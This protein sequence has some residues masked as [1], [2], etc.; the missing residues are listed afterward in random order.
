SAIT[1]PLGSRTRKRTSLRV[2]ASSSS[3]SIGFSAASRPMAAAAILA[4]SVIER[5]AVLVELRARLHVAGMADE[6]VQHHELGDGEADGL[7]FP[8]DG[9]ALQVEL[10]VADA[11]RRLGVG[12]LR[13]G[14][15][16]GA[17]EEDLDA[18]EELAHREG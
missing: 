1:R 4:C 11:Q 2:R 12:P 16:R 13:R 6:R 17:A 5:V 9:V 18:R 10:E 8:L 3:T 7:P 15:E 14:V